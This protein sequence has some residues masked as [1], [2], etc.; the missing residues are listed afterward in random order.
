LGNRTNTILQSAFF[1]ISNVIPYDLAVEQ[2]KKFIVTSYGRR[3][4]AVVKMNYAAVERG[5][6]VIEVEVPKEWANIEVK[7]EADTGRRARVHPEGGAPHERAARVR[8]A[9]IG[10]QAAVRTARGK[11][12]PPPT[13]KEGSVAAFVPVWNPETCIQCNQCAYVCP[14]ATIR[15][16]VLDEEEQKGVGE[17]RRSPEGD[18]QAVRRHG[19]SACRWTCST[20]WVAATAWMCAPVKREQKA[21]E[22]VPIATQL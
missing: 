13:R 4:E 20:V 16:F 5:G 2:M 19:D 12:V 15:P 17:G 8:P 3:G 11:W 18:R 21:L 9:G 22:M 14:H 10:L 1:K 7:D 6:N